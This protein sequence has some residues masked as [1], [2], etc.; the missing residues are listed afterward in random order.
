[1]PKIVK[2][3]SA[4]LKKTTAKQRAVK[5]VTTT[6][7]KKKVVRRKTVEEKLDTAVAKMTPESLKP[8]KVT[9]PDFLSFLVNSLENGV[10]LNYG[11]PKGNVGVL[12]RNPKEMESTIRYLKRQ[13]NKL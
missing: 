9:T 4:L 5:K 3:A 12:P 2:K 10:G 1:M 7:P 11:T 8:V 13:V 6:T